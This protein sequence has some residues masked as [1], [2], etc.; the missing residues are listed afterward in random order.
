M[1]RILM[2]SP[3]KRI[4]AATDFSSD[5]G[6]AVRRAAMLAT[7]HGAE[8]ELLHVASRSSLDAVRAWVRE[9]ADIAERLVEDARRLLEQ[10][11]ASLGRPATTRVAV[12]EVLDEILSDCPAGSTL[13][14]GAH[15]LNPL[16][17]AIL[18]TTAER[19]L[20]RG[21][22]PILIVRDAPQHDYR[23]VLAAVDL[24]PGS[25]NVLARA[26]AFAP[27]ASMAAVHAYDVAFEGA[28]QRAG[29]HAG[30][31][32]RHRAEAFEKALN[33]IRRLSEAASGDPTL[34]LPIA[35]RGHAARLILE[36]ERTLGADLVVIG[37][38][39]RSVLESV[40]LGSVTR[41]VL[42]DAKADV[43]VVHDA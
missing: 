31:I 20:G 9:P 39:R 10:C 38:R 21:P 40:L 3:V 22:L 37:K 33:A 36:H 29:V 2:Q 1:A 13:V 16:R 42:A 4:V 43:L 24:L 25:E 30:E 35:E 11:A 5:A 26:A 28:L 7:R 18:G 15:G 6:N 8:L 14:L 12:G 27:G 34:F 32:D 19:L 17:D 23:K 41:H